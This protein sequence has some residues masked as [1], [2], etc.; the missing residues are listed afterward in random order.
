MEYAA[1]RYVAGG[2]KNVRV[3]Y[4]ADGVIA[5]PEGAAIIAGCKHPEEAKA[6]VDY[7]LSRPVVDAIF[8]KYFRRP[9]RPDAVAVE[10][11]PSLKEITMLK[12]FDP[13]EAN[14]LEKDML[15]QWKKLVLQKQ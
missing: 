3:I 11:M 10:G 8:Q 1:H 7:L 13:A 4:P 12:D 15:A 14:A 6:L 2:A 9:A 5:A